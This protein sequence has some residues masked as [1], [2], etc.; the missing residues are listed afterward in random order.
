MT[1]QIT[2]ALA[3]RIREAREEANLSQRELAE[4]LG[5]SQRTLQGWE[6]G[7][8]P[9]PRHRRRLAEFMVGRQ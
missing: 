7:T 5:V 3:Y 6:Y 9:Q 2:K 1:E 4:L 8:K